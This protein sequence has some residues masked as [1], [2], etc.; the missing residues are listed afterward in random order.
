MRTFMRAVVSVQLEPIGMA[1]PFSASLCM[2][3][4]QRMRPSPEAMPILLSNALT[5]RKADGTRVARRITP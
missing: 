2:A 3:P 4:C 1:L 5:R